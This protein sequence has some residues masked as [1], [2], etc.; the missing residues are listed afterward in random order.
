[1]R[2][3]M[4]CA[5]AVLAAVLAC[6]GHAHAR[7]DENKAVSLQPTSIELCKSPGGAGEWPECKSGALGRQTQQ[8]DSAMRAALARMAPV[9]A[10][11]L[12]R[13]AVWFR[14]AVEAFTQEVEASNE[15]DR[16]L[17]GERL[18]RRLGD[19]RAMLGAA[20]RRTLAGRWANAFGEVRIAPAG[21][22]A[23][24]VEASTSVDYGTDSDETISCR[25]VAIVRVNAAGWLAGALER[26]ATAHV[27]PR[28][29][30]KQPEVPAMLRVRMQG[31]T[32]RLVAGDESVHGPASPEVGCE[33]ANQLTGTYFAADTDK[34]ASP[35]RPADAAESAAPS[36]DCRRPGTASEEEICA[37]PELAL[38]DLRLNRAWKALMPRLDP[39]SQRHLTADQKLW[40]ASQA[41]QFPIFLN[42][43]WEKRR[44]SVHHTALAR[45][46]LARLQRER[47][48][49]LEGFDERRSGLAGLWLAHNAI[50]EIEIGRNGSLTANGKKWDQGSWKDYC[51]Y[52]IAGVVKGGG[53]RS[54]AARIN[55]DT[56]EREGAMLVVNRDDDA[57]ARTRHERSGK[58][59]ADEPKCRRSSGMSSTARAF[60]VR[61]SPDVDAK[62][63]RIR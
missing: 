2:N 9:A 21:D 24:R 55:P 51:E 58:S 40:I 26:G 62:D 6:G 41:A 47:I 3:P 57:F 43:A 34:A 36:F 29:E 53:F 7:D 20:G 35:R 4:R 22:G 13:D 61:P 5:I 44:S 42:P 33:G 48:A 37:D 45:D 39:A 11:L 31:D 49:M 46:E 38:N 28:E 27:S 52:E 23:F 63:G 10:L 15:A 59:S 32:L 17:V 30:A 12:K 50:L 1:M 16:A 18:E 19:L 60:P 54:E 56:L 14:E 25:A 8:L